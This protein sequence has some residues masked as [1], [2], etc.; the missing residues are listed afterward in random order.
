MNRLAT[1]LMT[2]A[3]AFTFAS[4]A[5]AEESDLM[6]AMRKV[7]ESTRKLSDSQ[8]K[9]LEARRRYEEKQREL[10]EMA[11]KV[12]AVMGGREEAPKPK[13]VAKPV[14]AIPGSFKAKPI[15]LRPV[16]K[17]APAKKPSSARKGRLAAL[18]RPSR[19]AA[20]QAPVAPKAAPAPAAKPGSIYER[21]TFGKQ[22]EPGSI[23]K[24][25]TLKQR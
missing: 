3:L 20:L 2:A 8:R 13:P 21:L 18:K 10:V 16:A 6:R 9:L 22:P 4:P 25:L 15:L 24:R 23:Y 19:L 17:R 7:S 12:A 1:A 11:R 5:L 14:T